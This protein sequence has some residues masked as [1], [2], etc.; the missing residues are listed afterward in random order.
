MRGHHYQVGLDLPGRLK[1]CLSR[2]AEHHQKPM[3]DAD[4]FFSL[5][6]RHFCRARSLAV[7]G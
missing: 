6:L 2:V 7:L 3:L 1:D 5:E 4:E